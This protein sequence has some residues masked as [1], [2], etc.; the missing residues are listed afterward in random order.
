[1]TN[2]ITRNPKPGMEGR[3]RVCARSMVFIGKPVALTSEQLV[4]ETASGEVRIDLPYV[5]RVVPVPADAK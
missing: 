4:L 1:M 5:R 2:Q 3:V